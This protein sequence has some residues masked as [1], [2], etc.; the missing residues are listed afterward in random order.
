MAATDAALRL[1]VND[2]KAAYQA[3]QATIATLKTAG[4][5]LAAALGAN[6]TLIVQGWQ[7][8]ANATADNVTAVPIRVVT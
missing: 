6:G 1:L 4:V 5:A 2:Y 3:N 7:I 8:T